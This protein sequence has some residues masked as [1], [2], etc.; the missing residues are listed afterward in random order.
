M[1]PR[2]EPHSRL[3]DYGWRP[4][5]FLD[6]RGVGIIY[7]F[8]STLTPKLRISHTSVGIIYP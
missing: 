6:L 5:A 8:F 2:W 4:Q 7:G 1:L 3:T